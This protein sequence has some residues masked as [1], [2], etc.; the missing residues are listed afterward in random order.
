MDDR[1]RA[2]LPLTRPSGHT[3]RDGASR[4]DLYAA[5]D[6]GDWAAVGAA[7]DALLADSSLAAA[8]SGR[9]STM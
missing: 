6:A 3:R 2:V 1:R 7:A 9:S 4:Q 5:F 8:S